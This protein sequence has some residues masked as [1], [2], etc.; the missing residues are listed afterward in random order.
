[1]STA[2]RSGSPD[3]LAC[4]GNNQS[5]ALKQ[6][7]MAAR[8]SRCAKEREEARSKSGAILRLLTVRFRLVAFH[9]WTA[10]SAVTT[11]GRAS[12]SAGTAE[13]A[14]PSRALARPLAPPAWKAAAAAHHFTQ[15]FGGFQIFVLGDAAIAIGIHAFEVF[16]GITQ[17]SHA[18]A[19]LAA[20]AHAAARPAIWRTA[21][22]GAARTLR[23][24][25]GRTLGTLRLPLGRIASRRTTETLAAPWRAAFATG[26]A[27]ALAI[28]AAAHVLGGGGHFRLVHKAILVSVHSGKAVFCLPL[29][30]VAEFILADLAIAIAVHTLDKLRDTAAR[31]P[32]RRAALRALRRRSGF[33][34]RRRRRRVLGAGKAGQAEKANAMKK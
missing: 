21:L 13:A 32:W 34:W 29:A 20:G 6:N 18:A 24:S 14:A 25:L 7:G 1:M 16:F 30:H 12:F 5:A 19:A 26:P 27:H 33:V 22:G 2:A 3:A 28:R 15:A 17:H 9:R 31:I 11:A 10:E 4:D 23:L 8:P